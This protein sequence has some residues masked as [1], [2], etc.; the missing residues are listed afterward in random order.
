MSYNVDKLPEDPAQLSAWM[1]YRDAYYEKLSRVNPAAPPGSK[2]DPD[3]SAKELAE[4]MN[5]EMETRI[6]NSAIVYSEEIYA[7]K[8]QEDV[9]SEKKK[10][11]NAKKIAGIQQQ[12]DCKYLIEEEYQAPCCKLLR[13]KCLQTGKYVTKK[14]CKICQKNQDA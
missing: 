13:L 10:S 8:P 1:K 2:G 3:M 5:T 9:Q 6:S 11:D 12:I 7:V 4:L 14:E